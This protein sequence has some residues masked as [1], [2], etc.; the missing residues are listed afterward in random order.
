MIIESVI[1]QP[2]GGV[3]EHGDGKA[4]YDGLRLTVKYGDQ[5]GDI[6][7]DPAQP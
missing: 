1:Y 7:A 3:R 4:I 6:P 5:I 2:T